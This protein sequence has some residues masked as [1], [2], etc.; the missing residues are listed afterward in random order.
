MGAAFL[1]AMFVPKDQLKI[2]RNT[3]ESIYESSETVARHFCSVCGTFTF[4]VEKA[5][6]DYVIICAGTLDGDCTT[7]VTG[8]IYAT[9]KAPFH[10][11]YEN[12]P[13]CGENE[14]EVQHLFH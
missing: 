2:L 9:Y 1:P 13:R 11:L 8:D 3:A 7:P 10:Q 5:F 6:P 14:L 4:L 12:V